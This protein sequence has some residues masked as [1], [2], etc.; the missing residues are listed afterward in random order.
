MK[1]ELKEGLNLCSCGEDVISAEVRCL[2]DRGPVSGLSSMLCKEVLQGN[3][4]WTM[5]ELYFALSLCP[6]LGDL[7]ISLGTFYGNSIACPPAPVPTTSLVSI[8]YGS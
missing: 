3:P 7:Y 5:V 4:S 8:N 1:R 2:G 6:S